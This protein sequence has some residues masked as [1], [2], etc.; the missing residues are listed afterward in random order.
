[1]D[2]SQ[3]AEFDRQE[4]ARQAHT[5]FLNHR[6]YCPNCSCES[7]GGGYCSSCRVMMIEAERGDTTSW[8]LEDS[9]VTLDDDNYGDDFSSDGDDDDDAAGDKPEE[10][11]MPPDHHIYPKRFIDEFEKIEGFNIH[12]Y[13]VTLHQFQHSIIH[14][15]GWNDDWKMF[16]EKFREEGVEPDVVDVMSYGAHMIEMYGLGEAV[17]HPYRD[18]SGE[19]GR[20]IF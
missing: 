8:L 6:Q 18:Q 12:D 13:T 19:L 10:Y 7:P 4:A 14:S 3:R 2:E 20:H 5:D 11:P 16:F 17:I 15:E 1:M 9:L